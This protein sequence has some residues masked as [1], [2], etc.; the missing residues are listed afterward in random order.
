MSVQTKSQSTFPDL[1]YATRVH[2][3]QKDRRA[4]EAYRFFFPTVSMEAIF[5]GLRAVGA[6][7]R[8]S[9]V[10]LAAGPR[11]LGLTANSDTSYTVGVIDLGA[12]GPTVIE[13]PPG[14]LVGMVDDHHHRWVT[15]LGLSGPHGAHGG[16]HLIL[17]PG[18]DG[19]EPEGDWT[20]SRCPTHQALVI[21][22]GVPVDGDMAKAR[23][24]LETV[25]IRSADDSDARVEFLAWGHR[26][27]SSRIQV[28]RVR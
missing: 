13:I 24:L 23:S 27:V 25:V 8:A 19:P 21:L 7:D 20:V 18:W 6:K 17:P 5:R 1:E 10:I 9:A 2:R 14:P 4:L 15:D 11:H 26:L 16:R 3:Q 12:A 28:S 22:R